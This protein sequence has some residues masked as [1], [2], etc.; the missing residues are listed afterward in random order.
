MRSDGG[1]DE[2]SDA[3]VSLLQKVFQSHGNRSRWELVAL[4]HTLPEW[5]NPQ[6]GAVPIAY[7]DILKAGGKTELEIAVIEDELDGVALAETLLGAH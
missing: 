4:T 2:L 6:A 5:K 7:R 1:R 3:E